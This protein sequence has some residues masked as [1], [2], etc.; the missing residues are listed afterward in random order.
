MSPDRGRE[1]I[2]KCTI[3]QITSRVSDEGEIFWELFS[4]S[5]S[6]DSWVYLQL[7]EI[8]GGSEDGENSFFHR[9]YYRSV[10]H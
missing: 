4:Q 3:A 2:E 6:E 8:S 7:G 1:N 10:V 9:L 5:K